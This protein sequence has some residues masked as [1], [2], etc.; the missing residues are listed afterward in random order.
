MSECASARNTIMNVVSNQLEFLPASEGAAK[1]MTYVDEEERGDRKL[2]GD[3]LLVETS[4]EIPKP[5]LKYR[6]VQP[7]WENDVGWVL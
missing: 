2:S 7:P 6:P 3:H 1:E 4:L 5:T